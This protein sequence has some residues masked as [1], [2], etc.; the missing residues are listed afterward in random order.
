MAVDSP[1]SFPSGSSGGR[2]FEYIDH[3]VSGELRCTLRCTSVISSHASQFAC[4]RVCHTLETY[5][6]GDR[7]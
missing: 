1:V 3:V 2:V 7:P 4:N 5:C 6:D